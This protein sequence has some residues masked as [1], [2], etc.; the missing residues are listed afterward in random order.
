MTR[1]AVL[2]ITA[3]ANIFDNLKRTDKYFA[4]AKSS[5]A[6]LILLPE[7]FGFMGL[8]EGDKLK[9]AEED[10]N[11]LMQEHISR[12]CKK[13]KIWCI[14]GTIP[15]KSTNNKIFSR[16]IV[17][18]EYGA[19][20]AQ[21]DKIHLFDVKINQTETH[22]ESDATSPGTSLVVVD[23]P[24]GKIGLTV[25]YDLRFPRLYQDLS[26]KGAEIITVVAAFTA[27]TGK[28]HWEPLLRARAIENFVYMLAS[29]QTGKHENGRHT[30]GHSM[31]IDPWGKI[32]SKITKGEGLIV[33][34]IQTAKIKEC[35]EKIP[36]FEHRKTARWN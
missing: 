20:V 30:Y 19:K 26:D 14:A 5:G 33:S 6:K 28:A 36:I 23:S 32:V 13:F 11:G 16:S 10:G 8:K 34:E 27:I 22:N 3:S 15:I 12:L 7:N 35:R 17:F 18:D 1:A 21:Y 29:D 4:K 25:C 24:I 9:I 31:I 2:Q